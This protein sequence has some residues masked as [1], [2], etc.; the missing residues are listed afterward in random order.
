MDAERDTGRV[1]AD[2]TLN[3]SLPIRPGEALLVVER[4]VLDAAD[5]ARL[6]EGHPEERIGALVAWSRARGGLPDAS[7]RLEGSVASVTG[8]RPDGLRRGAPVRAPFARVPLVLADVS[9]WDGESHEVPVAD[10]YAILSAGER[11][12]P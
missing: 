1:R 7:G 6:G 9:A 12:T 4:L 3:P 2:G 11:G 10:G 8:E 5:L